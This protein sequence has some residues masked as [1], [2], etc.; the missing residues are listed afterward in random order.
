MIEVTR[1]DESV[2]KYDADTIDP[3][4]DGV[5]VLTKRPDTGN[6]KVVAVI[7]VAKFICVAVEGAFQ[8]PGKLADIASITPILK[9]IQ[10]A[11]T[12]GLK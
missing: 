3:K 5:I 7:P 4:H 8:R 6:P 9:N 12:Q 11:M 2:D 1:L 10:S